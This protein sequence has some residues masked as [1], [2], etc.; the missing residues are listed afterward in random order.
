[1]TLGARLRRLLRALGW[2]SWKHWRLLESW[3]ANRREACSGRLVCYR[4]ELL[5]LKDATVR[6]HCFQ[7]DGNGD[8]RLAPGFLELPGDK[9]TV[10]VERRPLLRCWESL[11]DGEGAR[12]YLDHILT[13]FMERVAWKNPY[14]NLQMLY[15]V[16]LATH[17]SGYTPEQ[18]SVVWLDS[19]PVS[20]Y[21]ELWLQRFREVHSISEIEEG[22][23][24][25]AV[26]C[27][28]HYTSSLSNCLGPRPPRWNEF[29]RFLLGNAATDTPPTL[30]FLSR[31]KAQ[32]R[33][34][35]NREALLSELRARLPKVEIRDVRME[36][37][38]LSEQI[39]VARTTRLLV[40]VHGAGLC[41]TSFLPPEAG[42]VELFPDIYHSFRFTFFNLARWDRRP[43]ARVICTR[44]NGHDDCV[45][46]VAR[47]AAEIEKAW[48]RVATQDE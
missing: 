34:L 30:T 16:W 19:H 3:R 13:V 15:E 27:R 39:E 18:T 32:I 6:P 36:E 35:I 20:P 25:H 8:F 7:P 41:Y 42:L 1:M 44:S 45:V 31:E 28:G 26:V 22:R 23:L 40:G 17:F 2:G 14:H 24:R 46:P 9:S 33:R 4:R 10:R 29:R 37:L 5:E 48:H 11:S 43:Y 38:T 47:A 21:R 12:K